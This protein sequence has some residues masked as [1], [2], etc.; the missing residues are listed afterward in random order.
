MTA[1]VYPTVPPV[2]LGL[3]R[4]FFYWR[5]HKAQYLIEL[6]TIEHH[7]GFLSLMYEQR[8]NGA[9]V[10]KDNS[11]VLQLTTERKL[12]ALLIKRD[13]LEKSNMKFFNDRRVEIIAKYKEYE[14]QIID[15]ELDVLKKAID[16]FNK[17]AE[18]EDPHYIVSQ[19]VK[20]LEERMRKEREELLRD[21]QMKEQKIVDQRTTINH[22]HNEVKGRAQA[23]DNSNAFA[24]AAPQAIPDEL[25]PIVQEP[26][27][28][29]RGAIH[30]VFTRLPEAERLA[31]QEEQGAFL[32]KLQNET[33]EELS[34][35]AQPAYIAPNL[36]L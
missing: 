4:E 2:T 14:R 29:W 20:E 10:T 12:N 25:P 15:V 5:Y 3:S 27:T 11:L 22:L 33:C 31:L 7:D 32:R 30:A 8:L 18:T 35:E 1:N 28:G 21:L 17:V 26:I 24:A 23:V 13:E 34:K 16:K 36:I 6:A 19:T 9:D